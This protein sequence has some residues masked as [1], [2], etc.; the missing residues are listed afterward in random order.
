MD[1]DSRR[2]LNAA[3]LVVAIVGL[4][5]IW[6]ETLPAFS[7]LE[8]IHLWSRTALVDGVELSV[9]PGDRIGIVIADVSGK[10][11][12]AALLMAGFL[13]LQAGEVFIDFPTKELEIEIIRTR[14]PNLKKKLVK[15]KPTR[16]KYFMLARIAIS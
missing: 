3:T 4:G 13:G 9:A 8:S 1:S 2:L 12:P 14:F 5:A 7:V 10:G 6:D 15:N 16:C 11:L